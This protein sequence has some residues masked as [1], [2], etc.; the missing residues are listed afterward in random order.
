ML[1][2]QQDLKVL[3]A[4][5]ALQVLKGLSVIP[6]HR[7]YKAILV[8]QALQAHRD[9]K[10]LQA[11]QVLLVLLAQRRHTLGLVIVYGS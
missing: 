10:V 11:L 6:D 9:P 2:D 5:Q 1:Q 3:S 7:V 8:T 4:T